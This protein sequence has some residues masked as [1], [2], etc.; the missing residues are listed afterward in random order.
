METENFY[1]VI[2]EFDFICDDIDELKERI[3]LTKS[4]NSKIAQ[5]ISNIE[6]ARKI[7]TELFPNIKSLAEDVREDLQAEFADMC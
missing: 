5:A 2:N 1:R 7:L 4:E 3:D 6:K